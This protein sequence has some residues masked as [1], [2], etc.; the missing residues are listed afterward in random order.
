MTRQVH[1]LTAP[2]AI[3]FLLASIVHVFA[4]TD[5]KDQNP[6]PASLPAPALSFGVI[7]IKPLDPSGPP[8]GSNL[9]PVPDGYEGRNISLSK[10]VHEAYGISDPK[11]VTGGPSWIDTNKFDVD[12]K[13]D[14]TD[15]DDAKNLTYRQKADML[16]PVLADRFRLKVH[17]V[18][19]EF[20]VY[21]LVVA[22]GGLKMQE[23]KPE[24]GEGVCRSLGYFGAGH[25]PM[26]HA[27]GCPTSKLAGFLPYQAGRPVIDKTGLAGLYDIKLNWAPENISAQKNVA[28]YPSIFKAL[29]EQ[30]GLALEPG[31]AT[32]D[33]LVI[34][35]AELPT[36]N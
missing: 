16:R 14:P 9:R 33:V 1:R 6:S 13:F 21:Y 35:S 3:S 28:G 32:F 15:I 20:P 11:L 36:P 19:K 26:M 4:Q 5:A 31:S 8:L 18:T 2:A 22:K 30:L 25:D 24:S 23:A 27:I 34:D 12:A 10:L 7:S 17:F 29:Q